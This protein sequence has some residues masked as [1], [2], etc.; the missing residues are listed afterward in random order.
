MNAPAEKRILIAG[1]TGYIGKAVVAELVRRGH[2][3]TA[4]VRQPTDVPDCQVV[5]T[6]LTDPETLTQSLQGASFD[7]V[8]SCI[9]SRSGV[10]DDAWRVDHG[11]NRNLLCIA[12]E[13]G[14]R[15]FLLLSAICVQRPK[16]A[17]QRAKLA[18][19]AELTESGLDYTIVRPTAFFKSL[20]GQIQ[21]V[22]A[23]KP[24]LVFGDGTETACKPIGEADL[25][26]FMVDC[27]ENTDA[28]NAILPI[29]G[30]GAA[31]TPREQGEMLFEL[32]GM[33][34]KFRSVS[35]RIFNFAAGLIAPV[36]M[37]WPAAARK[38]ELAR[39]GH[40]YA[41]ESMLVWDEDRQQYDAEATPETGRETLRDHYQRML[42][43]GLAGQELGEQKVF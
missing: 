36:G 37:V 35:P 26:E 34:P 21:R 4:L 25:A 40:Y 5:V 16:L 29:G 17:F 38:A 42:K 31:I 8:V 23:G 6:D 12:R 10:S 15:Q 19:E 11:A 18:F 32:T 24:F 41:T 22:R 13:A 39:I 3:V 30:P 28:R 14:A 43:H 20:S 7:V 1:A 2:S 9:A 33:P 27:M